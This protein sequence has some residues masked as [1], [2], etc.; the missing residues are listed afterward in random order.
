MAEPSKQTL[1]KTSTICQFEINFL[2]V[3]RTIFNDMDIVTTSTWE[4]RDGKEG[5]E[6]ERYFM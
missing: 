6:G 1:H 4:K 5:E 2:K 3:S